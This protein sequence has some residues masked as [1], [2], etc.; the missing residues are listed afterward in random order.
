MYSLLIAAIFLSASYHIFFDHKKIHRLCYFFKP[1]TT[2]LIIVLAY[3]QTNHFTGVHYL[4]LAGLAFSLLGDIFLMLQSDKFIHGLI[5]FF[6][7]HVFY[8]TAFLQPYG[9]S[10]NLFVIG[11]LLVYCA[12]L[13]AILLPKVGRLKIAIVAYAGILFAMVLTS[14]SFNHISELP[15]AYFAFIGAIIFM[16]SDSALAYAKFVKRHPYSQIFVLST[17]YFAQVLIATSLTN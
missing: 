9:F 13:L 1:L 3:G 5:S 10:Y 15:F 2:S 14:Y 11:C 6:I 4:I 12:V 16:L 8:I 17:Y 7:A